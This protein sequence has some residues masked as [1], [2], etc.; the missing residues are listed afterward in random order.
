MHEDATKKKPLKLVVTYNNHLTDIKIVVGMACLMPMLRGANKLMKLAQANDAYVC[1]YLIAVK[2]LQLDLNQW[3]TEEKFAYFQECFGD[4]NV[5]AE[6]R[7]D[8]IPMKW[9][10]DELDL[11]AS[12]IEFLTFDVKSN[13]IR[14]V[15][16]D[17]VTKWASPVTREVFVVILEGVKKQPTG[18]FH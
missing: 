9:E 7:H 6:T 16:L 5:L 8:S 2:K 13:N 14:A 4:F 12:G 18:S 10:V 1:E 15:Y 17:L 3:Y 11:N